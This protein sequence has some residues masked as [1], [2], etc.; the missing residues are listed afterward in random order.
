M[1]YLKSLILSKWVM[2]LTGL[3]LVGFVIGHT[4]GNLQMFVGPEVFNSYAAFLQGL[5]ELLWIMRIGILVCLVLHIITSIRLKVANNAAKPVSYQIKKHLRAKFTSKTMIWTGLMIF[6]FIVYHLLHF[7]TGHVH[8]EYYDYHESVVK[9]KTA[10]AG[11]VK[12]MPVPEEI[13]T[14][15]QNGV[16][17]VVQDEVKVAE[18]RHDVY[19]MVVLSFRNPL[20]VVFYVIGV[21]LLAFHLAHAIQSAFQTLGLNHPKY[22]GGIV[23]GSNILS[24]AIAAGLLSIPISIITGLLGGNI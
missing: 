8:G 9:E 2:A 20:I 3:A 13:K 11:D 24:F 17:Y 1:S 15:T 4:V 14:V 22:F 12:G 16:T 6:A 18:T 19:K 5:G 23:L 10:L 21:V 7:T